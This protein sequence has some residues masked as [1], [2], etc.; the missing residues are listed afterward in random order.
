MIN[1]YNPYYNPYMNNPYMNNMYM[2]SLNDFE[3]PNYYANNQFYHPYM[4]I[5]KYIKK[6]P[7]DYDSIRIK[8]NPFE[9][10]DINQNKFNTL[11]NPKI[12]ND[13][14]DYSDTNNNSNLIST[15]NLDSLEEMT[16]Q[17]KSK[18]EKKKKTKDY[19][20]ENDNNKIKKK[21]FNCIKCNSD[22]DTLE[23]FLTHLKEQCWTPFDESNFNCL[24]CGKRY[25]NNY[26][27]KRHLMKHTGI[28]RFTC[29]V[30][31]KGFTENCKL[32][33]HF[34]IHIKTPIKCEFCK[35]TFQ[36]NVTLDVHLQKFHPNEIPPP[37]EK[38]HFYE[39]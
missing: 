31:G 26:N 34:E 30:C 22:F 1:Q 24:Y 38:M 39:I 5:S 33:K 28:Y 7:Y 36:N 29:P 27:L 8:R 12:K 37:K 9:N 2:N 35:Y 15:K 20:R 21:E 16:E 14:S 32:R 23:H 4:N 3:N 17:Y 10:E 6:N 25:K 18:N 11:K 13:T 19:K